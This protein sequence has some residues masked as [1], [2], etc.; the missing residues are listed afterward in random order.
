MDWVAI[1]KS[2]TEEYCRLVDV[3]KVDVNILRR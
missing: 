3:T 1:K 2:S